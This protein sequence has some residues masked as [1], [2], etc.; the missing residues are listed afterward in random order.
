[1]RKTQFR[2]LPSVTFAFA[3]LLCSCLLALGAKDQKLKPEELV[4][5]HLASLGS[6]EARAAAK[7]RIAAGDAE[8]VFRLNAQGV[9]KGKG[10]V[11]SEGR[12]LRIAMNFNAGDYT[13]E[14]LVYD[15]DK[16]NVG[17]IRPG[18]RSMLLSFIYTHNT[19]ILE[20]L[21]GG[22]MSTA[23]PLLDLATRQAKL[24][25]TGLK[26]IEGK[27]LHEVRYRPK[28]GAG[29]LQITLYFDPETF[30]HVRSQ[31]LL[32]IPE[33]MA[34]DPSETARQTNT[35]YQL[36]ETFSDFKTA[37]GLTLPSTYKLNFTASGQ[38]S[39]MGEWTLTA[40][41]VLHGQQLDARQFSV[42]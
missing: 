26:K 27:Q 35:V 32:N 7:N 41:Q 34:H 28:K 40:T 42:P 10:H 2:V 31:Y 17:Q 3:L 18:Q 4:E 39:F 36:V 19:P 21:L 38:G 14:Y 16:V 30:H 1:M 11:M 9:I 25:Y 12:S 33:G 15:G 6:P 8:V 5:R 13:G 37:D 24:D 29:D 20:G 22:T 23:W